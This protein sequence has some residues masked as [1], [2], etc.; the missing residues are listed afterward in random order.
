MLGIRY[1]K[2]AKIVIITKNIITYYFLVLYYICP[3]NI[4]PIFLKLYILLLYIYISITIYLLMDVYISFSDIQNPNNIA[5]WRQQSIN[6]DVLE[7]S[8]VTAN[9]FLHFLELLYFILINPHILPTLSA[10]RTG[11]CNGLGELQSQCP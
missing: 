11:S 1:Q 6:I 9:F 7:N 2:Y 4:H 8:S 5:K 3:I 10:S